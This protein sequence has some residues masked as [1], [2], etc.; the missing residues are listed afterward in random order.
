M[1]TIS[2]LSPQK[3]FKHLTL[4]TFNRVGPKQKKTQLATPPAF[5]GIPA[6]KAG[7]VFKVM[8]RG[9]V[10]TIATK[11]P[12]GFKASPVDKETRRVYCAKAS[13]AQKNAR[14]GGLDF[15]LWIGRASQKYLTIGDIV[16]LKKGSKLTLLLLDRNVGDRVATRVPPFQLYT[17]AYF[18]RP[19]RAV[20][21]H[22]HDLTGTLDFDGEEGVFTFDVNY[23][24]R[25]W[26]PLNKDGVL[27]AKDN[28]TRRPL[29]GKATHYKTMSKKTHVGMRGPIVLWSKLKTMP[30]VFTP[31]S[32]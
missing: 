19:Q 30:K 15:N 7:L 18:F 22:D 12:A 1:P 32:K 5:V 20:Y 27:P 23:K 21:T 28:Q 3:C 26:Y 11:I 6:P 17:P 24:P 31:Y 9:V 14:L 13:T 4:Y 2:S 16:K 29:L 25:H 10:S 8:R